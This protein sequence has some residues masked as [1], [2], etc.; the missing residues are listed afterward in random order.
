[1]GF[2]DKKFIRP[3]KRDVDKPTRHLYVSGIG[4]EFKTDISDLRTFF[5]QFGEL[6]EPNNSES[7][8]DVGDFGD[9]Y[10][11][12][13]R[14]YCFVSFKSI[15]SATVS[16]NALNKEDVSIPSLGV[17]GLLVKFATSAADKSGPP[18]AE[19]T[20]ST[21]HIHIEGLSVIENFISEEEEEA[22]LNT[23]GNDD[24]PAWKE[25]LNRRVQHYGFPFNYRTLMVDYTKPTLPLSSLAKVM[26]DKVEH[27][28]LERTGKSVIEES[29]NQLTINEYWSNQGI[30]SH[31][32]TEVCFGSKLFVINI[33]GD[34]VMTMTR[35]S[36]S[37]SSPPIEEMGSSSSTEVETDDKST[38][39]E[40]EDSSSDTPKESTSSSTSI[41]LRKHVYLP[42][43]SLLIL[44]KDARYLWSHGISPR[45]YD[46]VNGQL[47]PRKRRL[48]FTFR[49]VLKPPPLPTKQLLSG[50]IEEEHVVKVYDAIAI[51]W[52]H[53][54]GK[55]K[56]YWNLVK[57]FIE[58]L[59]AGS[60]LADI[61]SGD[62]KYFGVNPNIFTI[63]CDRSLQLLE[64]SKESNQETFC[65]DAVLLPFLS[66]TFDAAIC[67]A[68][69]HHIATIERR[70]SLI[71][72]LLRITKTNGII[73]LQAWALEQESSS[74]HTF[75]S[76]DIMVPWKLNKRFINPNNNTEVSDSS[77]GSSQKGSAK[78]KK[79]QKGKNRKEKEKANAINETQQQ[80]I[81]EEEQAS[82]NQ[83]DVEKAT[84]ETITVDKEEKCVSS[85]NAIEKKD[86]DDELIVYERYCHVY[87]E[88]E[89]VDLCS[90][91][92]NCQIIESG[93]EK[94][95]WFLKLQKIDDP[96]LRENNSP[97]SSKEYSVPK[98]ITRLSVEGKI[99]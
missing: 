53:T 8:N 22:L 38:G 52:N 88:G 42:R 14:R 63:G 39:E 78:E 71:S 36:S 24:N 28:D 35:K 82:L 46:K 18:E 77:G 44:E 95:N 49:H 97:L 60:L 9:F 5:S 48:S 85:V 96:R 87:R 2:K 21:D 30:A 92:P 55:R 94:G 93:Y 20:S 65:C 11:P 90:R 56:V 57:E 3:S 76:Q 59:P 47:I 89:L 54:R 98:V 40:E 84:S 73:F 4:H 41:T 15:E 83:N 37:S 74:I 58:N 75:T 79:K 50:S 25:S 69:L 91:I 45:K 7:D 51:H 12:L 72:E 70:Y 10:M 26:A 67:I 43:R 32:D 16:F 27:H 86:K 29:I 62:G 17:T 66:N 33:C 80:F 61:G 31:I 64:V 34:I 23:Y 99:L 81:P 6:E 1:M 19:C 13:D 68:V